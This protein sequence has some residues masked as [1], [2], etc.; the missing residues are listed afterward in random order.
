MIPIP[1]GTDR[2][3]RRF[4][5]MNVALIAANVVVFFLSNTLGQRLGPGIIMSPIR[6][7]WTRFML[8]PTNP[9]LYQFITYQ[10][11]H[12]GWSHIGFNMLFLYVFGNN[13]NEK[14]GHIGY[15]LFYL[16]GGVLAGCG[17]MMMSNSPTLGASGSISAVTG[18]FLALLPR[19]HIKIF[20]WFVI[21]MDVW[22]IPS[23]YFILFKV[24]QDVFEQITGSNGVAYMAHLTGTVAGFAIG[25]LL[26]VANLVQRDH[27]DILAM[28]S[29]QRRRQGYRSV[30]AR[31]YDPFQ[32][33]AMGGASATG[34]ARAAGSK[35][36]NKMSNS[37]PRIE[38]LRAE[39]SRLLRI[40]QTED[41]AARYLELRQIDP[42]QVLT[43]QEQVD[44]ASQ[45]MAM[46]HHVE[47]AA[48]YEGY[49][50]AYPSGGAGQQD[51]ITL[52]LGLIYARYVGNAARARELLQKVLPGLHDPKEREMAEAELRQLGAP[53]PA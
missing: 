38:S 32:G 53:P 17:Q 12:E 6:P 18:L 35:A 45:L 22:E 5:W 52:M 50:A 42:T 20:I 7:E 30:V 46:H 11:L 47:A 1:F 43:G 33:R 40:H 15:L 31:G 3:Q 29:R 49:L 48:A 21:Y 23:M 26:L 10:F 44:V 39:I 34:D 24:G 9:H 51:Q 41:A 27:Y 14:L 25:L 19:I 13:L 2:P 4:P 36:A 37:D 16:A 28:L 8:T